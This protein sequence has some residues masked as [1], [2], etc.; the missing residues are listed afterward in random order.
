MITLQENGPEGAAY[1]PDLSKR[2][3]VLANTERLKLLQALMAGGRDPAG[4]SEETGIQLNAVRR[5]LR[6]LVSAGLVNVL[7]A[8]NWNTYDIDSTGI[9]L[10]TASLVQQLSAGTPRSASPA[11]V[12]DDDALD[13]YTV[14]VPVPPGR[15]LTCS[16]SGFVRKVLDDLDRVLGEARIYHGQLQHLSSQVLT[17]HEAERKRIARELH[18]DTG[19]A[20]TSILVRL[21]LLE[22]TAE[23]ETVRG[24]VEELRELTSNALEAVRRMAVD[25]RPPALDDLGLVPALHSYAD[26]YSNSW[27]INVT[28]SAEGLKK[29]LPANVELVLYRIVQEALTNVAKHSGASSVAVK[30]RRRS[31]IV[32]V[33]VADDGRGFDLRDVTRT[34]GS[35]L[36]LFGMRERLALVGGTVAIESASGRGTTIIAR[37]PLRGQS[38]NHSKGE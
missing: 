30:L 32:T 25:L 22:K 20:L 38:H 36:G 11:R 28:F 10:L 16:N 23:D 2:L 31:N 26:K 27:T 15:C 21:R 34:E 6:V 8:E 17:A 37:V 12:R 18:D 7:P 1:S 19:Q 13:V 3:Q 9:T 24:N 29:R 4:L 14:D 33:T 5:H 35:G